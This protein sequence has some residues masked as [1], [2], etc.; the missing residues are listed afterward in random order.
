[1]SRRHVYYS[2]RVLAKLEPQNYLCIIHDKMDQSKT[3]LPKLNPLPKSLSGFG[4][5]LLV[6]LTS[7]F[8]HGRDPRLYAHFS[9]TGLWPGDSDF[10]V[11]SLAKCLRDLEEYSGDR[12]GDLSNNQ[13][14]SSH[15]IFR[16]VMDCQAFKFGYL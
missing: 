6:A 14:T 4:H 3:W 9:L 10:T 15:P 13:F 8:V 11:T 12:S 5:A 2:D 1:M 7:M 16:T